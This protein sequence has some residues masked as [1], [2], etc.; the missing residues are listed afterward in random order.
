MAT[1]ARDVRVTLPL[2]GIGGFIEVAWATESSDPEVR[3]GQKLEVERWE[4]FPILKNVALPLSGGKGA[5][6]RRRVFSD[7]RFACVAIFDLKTV[8]D[9]EPANQFGAQPF[10]DGRLEGSPG[11]IERFHVGMRFQC[12]D[13]TFH[14]QPELTS[15]ARPHANEREGIYYFCPR[16]L[17]SEARVLDASQGKP[18]DGCVKAIFR[19]E[20][21]TPLERWVDGVRIA[22][23]GMGFDPN[24][25]E[26][27]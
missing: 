5:M 1:D 12:G 20:G 15:M 17:L 25:K 3:A 8:F 7:F 14:S 24:P 6:S 13:P 16:V 10:L 19:G 4:I 22:L 18:P 21:S 23:G 9:N 11:E 26:G 27:E 2:L